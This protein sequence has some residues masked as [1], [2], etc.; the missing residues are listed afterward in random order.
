[1][2]LSFIILGILIISTVIVVASILDAPTIDDEN[3][4]M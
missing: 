4:E 2:K 1:M 3:M